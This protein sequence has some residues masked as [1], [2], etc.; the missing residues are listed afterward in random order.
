MRAVVQYKLNVPLLINIR[1]GRVVRV[2]DFHAK[3]PEFE[4][5]PIPTTG[6][7]I[8]SECRK[9]EPDTTNMKNFVI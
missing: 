7:K 9:L 3:G 5:H 8:F 1:S 4:S 2:A 6:K